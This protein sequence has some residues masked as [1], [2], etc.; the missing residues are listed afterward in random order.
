MTARSQALAL[1]KIRLDGG[2]QPRASIYEEL[3]TDYAEDLGGGA[4]FP[5]IIVFYDGTDYWL[6]DGFHRVL[7]FKAAGRQKIASD[8]RQGTQRDA[9]LFSCGVNAVHGRRRTNADK[10]RAVLKL[11][12]DDEWRKWSNREIANRC[13]VG[14]TLADEMRRSLTARNG[15]S[16]PTERRYTTRHGSEAVM[17]TERIGRVFLKNEATW[18]PGMKEEASK[19]ENRHLDPALVN[20]SYVAIE[21]MERLASLDVSPRDYIEDLPPFLEQV[22]EKSLAQ[23]YAWLSEFYSTWRSR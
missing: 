16:E 22:V 15:Q 2:T 13:A 20:R 14:H 1:S 17:R 19:P 9:V 18:P 6:A 4:T 3:V 7:A 12:S 5:E 11:L 8:I 10:R 23:A 21:A